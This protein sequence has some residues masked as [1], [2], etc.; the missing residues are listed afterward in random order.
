MLYNV[1]IKYVKISHLWQCV[2]CF[3]CHLSIIF[4]NMFIKWLDSVRW[5]ILSKRKSFS[6]LNIISTAS[7]HKIIIRIKP[8]VYLMLP[9]PL[10][11]SNHLFFAKQ[12]LQ[13]ACI[14]VN[15]NLYF[16]CFFEIDENTQCNGD[17]I[18]IIFQKFNQSPFI[19]THTDLEILLLSVKCSS[20]AFLSLWQIQIH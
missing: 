2:D 4:I 3:S 11:F 19:A 8:Q 17:F 20:V 1:M 10:L 15:H 14:W 16:L 12:F 18:A 5:Q 9:S 6:L 7:K 13:D